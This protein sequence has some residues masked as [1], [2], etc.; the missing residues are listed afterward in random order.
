MNNRTVIDWLL[1]W[2]T[3]DWTQFGAGWWAVLIIAFILL[4]NCLFVLIGIG[5]ERRHDRRL[6]EVGGAL[7]GILLLPGP[8]PAGTGGRP[9]LVQAQ[10]VMSPAPLGLF[11]ARIRRLLGGRLIHDQRL[12]ER[13]RREV[14]LRL[15]E[16][17]QAVGAGILAGLEITHIPFGKHQIGVMATATALIGTPAAGPAMPGVTEAVGMLPPRSR[18]ELALAV[19]LVA[20]LALLAMW[21]DQAALRFGKNAND[22]VQEYLADK[23]RP[24]KKPA[25]E[26]GAPTGTPSPEP[27]PP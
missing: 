26:K 4:F 1:F 23:V 17:A 6:A 7:A 2:F 12:V 25:K 15:R 21:I 19:I 22:F 3:F 9:H 13:A 20:G 5:Q 8:P 24:D 27:K 16:Q 10:V 14:L 11:H 18:L